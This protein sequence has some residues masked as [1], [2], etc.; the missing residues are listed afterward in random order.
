MSQLASFLECAFL[1]RE[2]NAEAQAIFENID[3]MDTLTMSKLRPC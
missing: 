2:S 1:S 3:C